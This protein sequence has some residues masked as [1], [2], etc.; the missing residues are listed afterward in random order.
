MALS[1]KTIICDEFISEDIIN[2]PILKLIVINDEEDFVELADMVAQQDPMGM[3]RR[4]I[5]IKNCDH[6]SVYDQ[7]PD[8]SVE[9]NNVK[10]FSLSTINKA[11]RIIDIDDDINFIRID[12][13]YIEAGKPEYN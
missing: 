5:W 11:A 12:E 10:A 7:I 3:D 1:E 8:L 4:V 13:A 9:L 2:D 6:Q